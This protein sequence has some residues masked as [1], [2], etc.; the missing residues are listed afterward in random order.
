MAN[1]SKRQRATERR[2]MVEKM[3][4]EQKA[5][6]RR[7]SLIG[8]AVVVV[9][10]LGIAGGVFF[11][12]HKSSSGSG[13]G[14]ID[15][16]KQVIPTTP[17]GTA[18]VQPKPST[19]KNPTDISGVVAYDTGSWPGPNDPGGTELGHDHVDGPVTYAVT[20]PVG[21]P[22]NPVWMNAG[23]YTE[24]VPSERAVHNMEHGVVWVTYRPDLPKS[25]VDQLTALFERQSMISEPGDGGRSNRFVDVS[26]WAT[27][28]LPAPVV[29]SAWGY[30][31]KVQ[32]ASDP[33]LQQFIDTF[34]RNQRYAPEYG[35]AVDGIPVSTGGNPALGSSQP[36]L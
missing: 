27:N 35:A 18:I 36:N 3:Q 28:D 21:G 11:S 26:P 5:H 14:T 7:R 25:Q 20:P 13:G 1:Q 24:P 17:T 12:V 30:Q 10:L 9:L 22:H 2:A 6:E 32:S 16:A 31:L 15:V 19:T 4:R 33:R 8:A 34:R 29:I 23:L